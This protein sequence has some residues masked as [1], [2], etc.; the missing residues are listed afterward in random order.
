M[1]LSIDLTMSQVKF[2]KFSF[3]YK[4]V[5][6]FEIK[7]TFYYKKVNPVIKINFTL[8]YIYTP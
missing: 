2:T 6:N 1:W 8:L 5:Q 3:Y 7:L 4:N